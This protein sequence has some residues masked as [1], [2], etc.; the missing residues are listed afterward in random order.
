MRAN[1]SQPVFYDKWSDEIESDLDFSG[2]LLLWSAYDE[3]SGTGSRPPLPHG[4]HRAKRRSAMH[5]PRA[6]PNRLIA[7]Y[8]YSEHVGT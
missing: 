2:P 3:D 4:W 7:M 5:D 1:N 8:A 6:N